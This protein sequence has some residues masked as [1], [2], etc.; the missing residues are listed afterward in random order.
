M[1]TYQLNNGKRLQVAL[2]DAFRQKVFGNN[3]RIRYAIAKQEWP[4]TLLQYVDEYVAMLDYRYVWE[5]LD[6]YGPQCVTLRITAETSNQIDALVEIDLTAE[7]VGESVDRWT[8][9]NVTI[10]GVI[11]EHSISLIESEITDL[12]DDTPRLIFPFA[13]YKTARTY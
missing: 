4:N 13:W 5:Y 9:D 8:I 2:S 3:A 1:N 6:E 11:D 7:Q 10:G 12:A